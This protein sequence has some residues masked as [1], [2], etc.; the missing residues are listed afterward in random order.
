MSTTL[1]VIIGLGCML[2]IVDL[3]V[4]TLWIRNRSPRKQKVTERKVEKK[5]VPVSKPSKPALQ[6]TGDIQTI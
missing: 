5:A 1:M 2:I 4:F 6:D 3:I